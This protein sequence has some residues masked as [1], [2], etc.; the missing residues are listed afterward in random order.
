MEAAIIEEETIEGNP[1]RQDRNLMTQRGKESK[2]SEKQSTAA[3][4]VEWLSS[5]EVAKL[6]GDLAGG[7]RR[8]RQ[9]AA[10]QLGLVPEEALTSLKP[11]IGSL[12]DALNRPEAQ[13]RWECLDLL[14]KLVPIDSRS[15]EK[16]IAG[17]ETA[18][19]DEE[20]GTL[21]LAA[22]RFLCRIGATTELRSKKTWP[23]IDEALQCC[24]GDYEFSDMMIAVLA[25]SEGKLDAEVKQELR[26]RVAFDAENSRGSLRRHSLQILDNL[27]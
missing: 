10:K 12:V 6:A 5:D 25:Y 20:N 22:M 19:F 16:A 18:L 3:Q 24:H 2:A 15:C 11:H 1:F 27:S 13:T 23:L 21:R 17:A 14:T 4:E 26:A 7:S 8:D 9:N